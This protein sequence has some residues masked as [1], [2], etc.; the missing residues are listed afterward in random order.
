MT[1]EPTIGLGAVLEIVL[2]L[3]GVAG[4][5]FT[6]KERLSQLWSRAQE[7]EKQHDENQK[8][9]AGIELQI[10]R[11]CVQVGDFRRFEDKLELRFKS[12]EH[13]VNNS[14]L[15]TVAAVKEAVRDV[16]SPRGRE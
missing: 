11:E 1:F 14:A 10:A 13:A 7:Q 15:K 5:W 3:L 4:I 8:R 6:S 12:V 2:T 9:M 16:V